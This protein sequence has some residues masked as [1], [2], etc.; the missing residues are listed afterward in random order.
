MIKK[1]EIRRLSKEFIT[2][3]PEKFYPEFENKTTRPFIVFLIRIE[4]H[5]FAIPFRTHMN[6]RYGY[7][8]NKTNLS[9]RSSTGLDFTKAVLVDDQKLLGEK[10][11]VDNMEYKELENKYYFIRKQFVQ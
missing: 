9:T 5:T 4:N 8:F 3:Y 1:Y 6:H 11:K 10:A 7:K 2:R